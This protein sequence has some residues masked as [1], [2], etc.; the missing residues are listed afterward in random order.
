MLGDVGCKKWVSVGT[1]RM[2]RFRI[3]KRWKRG[4]AVPNKNGRCWE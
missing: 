4:F 1:V 3:K 2:K